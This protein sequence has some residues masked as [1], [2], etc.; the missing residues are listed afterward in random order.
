[1]AIEARLDTRELDRKLKRLSRVQQ[2]GAVK[3]ANDR[4][5]KAMRTVAKREVG[6]RLALPQK[7]I[8]PAIYSKPTRKSRIGA[9][10]AVSARG[11]DV[12]KFP[13]WKPAKGTKNTPGGVK[14]RILKRGS[15][16]LIPHAFEATV[17]GGSTAEK[18]SLFQR[19]KI[20]A[21]YAGRL[22]I[23]K[24]I[25]TSAAQ[26]LSEKGVRFRILNRGFAVMQSEL[27]RE[28]QRRAKG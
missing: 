14:V 26:Q 28:I 12:Y 7:L 10:I 21:T 6:L 20:G 22:P 25:T 15:R 24:V 2:F 23:R 4:A 3:R 16:K 13:N 17:R 9:E 18:R 19:K 27:A 5:T 8:D 1:M 11:I